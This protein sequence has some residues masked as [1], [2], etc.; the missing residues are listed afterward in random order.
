MGNIA[1]ALVKEQLAG[2]L[3]QVAIAIEAGMDVIPV[4][5]YG[6]YHIEKGFPTRDVETVRRML[7]HYPSMSR[8]VRLGTI[9][10]VRFEFVAAREI[11]QVLS[12][13][14][15]SEWEQTLCIR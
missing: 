15:P 3:E 11:I 8:G 14:E 10:A 5:Y 2:R 6:R 12:A 4:V 13:D 9:I 7:E 1:K